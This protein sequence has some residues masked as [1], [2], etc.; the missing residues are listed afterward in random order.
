M[1]KVNRCPKGVGLGNIFIK[2]LQKKKKI[3]NFL[4]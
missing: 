1:R 3:T 4:N 2:F